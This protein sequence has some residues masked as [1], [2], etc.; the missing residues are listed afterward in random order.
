MYFPLHIVDK[1]LPC[2]WHELLLTLYVRQ[3][4]QS[5]SQTTLNQV[6][7]VISAASLPQARSTRKYVTYLCHYVPISVEL[8]VHVSVSL[9][10]IILFKLDCWRQSGSISV[11]VNRFQGH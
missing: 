9:W 10:S 6:L 8:T 7:S 11:R 1:R 2:C 3:N 5:H 4:S